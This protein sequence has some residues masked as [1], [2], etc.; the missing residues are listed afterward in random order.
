MKSNAR[1]DNSLSVVG[2][3]HKEAHDSPSTLRVQSRGRL[4]QE[5]QK[6]GL[7]SELDS[8]SQPLPLLDT[9]ATNDSIGILLQTTH[10]QTFLN[11]RPLLFHRNIL[12]LTKNGREKDRLA[13]G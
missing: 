2:Q 6:L 8:D 10:Q 13:D 4:I 5:Q 7:S 11:I 3:S 12:R 1:A 9:Q